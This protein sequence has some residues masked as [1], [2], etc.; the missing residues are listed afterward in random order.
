VTVSL[1]STRKVA[2]IGFKVE[3]VQ[4]EIEVGGQEKRIVANKGT[5]DIFFPADYTG[6]VDVTIQGSKPGS[7]TDEGTVTIP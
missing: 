1:I 7:P 2:V 5:A 4:A 3:G 6:H